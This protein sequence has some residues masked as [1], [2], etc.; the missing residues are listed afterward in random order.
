VSKKRGCPH[1]LCPNNDV[2]WII[3]FPDKEGLVP[4]H[5][6]CDLSPERAWSRYTDGRK[7]G[8]ARGYVAAKFRLHL[9]VAGPARPPGTERRGDEDAV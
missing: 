5:H 3:C 4:L 7:A 6:T 2:A 9:M 1:E 8:Q